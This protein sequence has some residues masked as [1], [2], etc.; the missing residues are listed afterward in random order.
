M[1]DVIGGVIY[2]AAEAKKKALAALEE[3][4]ATGQTKHKGS[5]ANMSLGGGKS[6]ALD[7]T[8]DRAVEDGLHFSV[9]AGSWNNHFC[10]LVYLKYSHS[11]E[12]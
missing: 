4:R 5:V 6:Q 11:R 2:A 12:R 9:A 3:F 8:V 1:S 10:A 7:D